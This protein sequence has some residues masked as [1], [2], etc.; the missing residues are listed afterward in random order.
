[1]FSGFRRIILFT[2]IFESCNTTLK[3]TICPRHRE[4]YGTRWMCNKKS[5]AVPATWS[6]HKNSNPKGDRG[7]TF[8][9][10]RDIY[11]LTKFLVPVGSRKYYRQTIVIDPKEEEENNARKMKKK[12]V[13]HHL[14]ICLSFL[15]LNLVLSGSFITFN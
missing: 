11:H 10:S 13:Q 7:I 3:T 1:M 12:P 2:G 6:S 5:C 9:Q 15:S 14:R 8:V 4:L